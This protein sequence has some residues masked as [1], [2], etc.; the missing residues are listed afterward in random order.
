MNKSNS[1]ITTK[2]CRPGM[3]SPIM[4]MG[5]KHF[6]NLHRLIKS[7]QVDIT[8]TGAFDQIANLVVITSGLLVTILSSSPVIIDDDEVGGLVS[9]AWSQDCNTFLGLTGIQ[10]HYHCIQ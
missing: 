4:S 7:I 10:L 5:Q 6:H 9:I 1:I 8:T 3:N 2:P